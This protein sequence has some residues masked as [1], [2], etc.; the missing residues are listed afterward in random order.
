[1]KT[2]PP[3]TARNATSRVAIRAGND[4]SHHL[5][6][7]RAGAVSSAALRPESEALDG[8]ILRVTVRVGNGLG[9]E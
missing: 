4:T 7:S 1:M 2:A 6:I 3:A 5:A 8:L 9:R